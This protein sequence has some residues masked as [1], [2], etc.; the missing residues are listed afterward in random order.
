MQKLLLFGNDQIL[1]LI[2]GG[3]RNDLLVNKVGLLG[4]RTAV[5]DLLGVGRANTGKRVELLFRGGIDVDEIG[6]GSSGRLFRGG[7]GLRVRHGNADAQDEDE[8]DKQD[9]NGI[10]LHAMFSLRW[11]DSTKTDWGKLILFGGAIAGF[12]GVGLAH[13]FALLSFAVV[14]R[15]GLVVDAGIGVD[16]DHAVAVGGR[17]LLGSGGFR[18]R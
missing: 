4:V 6:R 17:R 5:D 18:R 7:A 3:L 1:D 15:A 10:S 13:V 8:S 2:V 14:A 11:C 12:D 9:A 16:P